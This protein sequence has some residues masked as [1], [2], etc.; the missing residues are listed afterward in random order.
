MQVEAKLVLPSE[1]AF[2]RTLTAL[3]LITA[4][5]P[6]VVQQS[7]LFLDGPNGELAAA[8]VLCRVRTQRAANDPTGRA[9]SVV[10]LKEH[11]EVD[12]GSSL[13]FVCEAA[14]DDNATAADHAALVAAIAATSVG[15][16]VRGKFGPS[17]TEL[18]SIG[19]FENTRHTFQ[20]SSAT[21]PQGAAPI[22]L[23]VDRTA[24]PFGTVFEIEVPSA[25]A[26]VHDLIDELR[27]LLAAHG[28]TEVQLG[29]ASKFQ[30]FDAGMRAM[31]SATTSHMRVEAKVLLASAEDYNR[32]IAALL[33]DHVGTA[34]QVN[35]CFDGAQGELSS[36]GAYLRLRTVANGTR[37]VTV[38]EHSGV[39]ESSGLSWVQEEALPSDVATAL[40]AGNARPL[41]QYRSAGGVAQALTDRFGISLDTALLCPVGSFLT[42]RSTFR[43]PAA[44]SLQHGLSIRVDRTQYPSGVMRFEVEVADISVPV[45]DVIDLLNASLDAAGVAHAPCESTKFQQLFEDVRN[46]SA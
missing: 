27:R 21:L 43:W 28:I 5:A 41:L 39:T 4:A 46:S 2:Q 26:P 16:A 35:T 8:N 14:L 23:K 33:P 44:A 22:P 13:S 20:W 17:L 29:T 1:G 32:L 34:E 24:Y 18:R 12:E 36:R 31:G 9:P 38:K 19:G 42:R 40:E 10:T 7:N 45:H 11:T 15:E 30:Q 3:E 25:G 6:H 37:L